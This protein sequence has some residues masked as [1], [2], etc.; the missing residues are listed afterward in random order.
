MSP[1]LDGPGPAGAAPGGAGLGGHLLTRADLL[2]EAVAWPVTGERVL[3]AGSFTALV[4]DDITAPDG[5]TLQR[6][7]LRHPG[8]VGIIALDADGRVAL[9]RQYRHAVRHR[10]IEPPA[11]L[12][13]VD[14]EA[15][16]LAAERELAE[17]VGLAADTWHVLVDLFTTPGII[18]ESL[19]VFLARDLHPAD[20]PDGFVKS[21]EE[22]EMELSWAP[23]ADLVDAV[24]AGDLHNPTMVSGVLATWAAVQRHDQFA[25]L[26]PA[27]APW[28]ARDRLRTVHHG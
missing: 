14:G 8:A 19:R 28:P 11:G 15:Y 20:A 1:E 2:D 10:L 27:D 22:A 25:S 24:L 12:L 5:E 7:Y 9:V 16:V 4:Q 21:G 18:G 6:E 13:D 23:L 3:G 26:R 17:E